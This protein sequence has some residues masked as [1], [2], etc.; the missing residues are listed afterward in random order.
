MGINLKRSGV[1]ICAFEAV[2]CDADLH[3]VRRV[4]NA[5]GPASIGDPGSI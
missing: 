3:E 2:N 1:C 4:D 5:P